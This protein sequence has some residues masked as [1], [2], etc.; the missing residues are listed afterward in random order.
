MNSLVVLFS[1]MAVA[2]AKPSHLV[3]FPGAPSAYTSESRVDVHS[4]PSI[5]TSAA[6]LQAKALAEGHFIHKRSAALVASVLGAVA[7]VAS[8]HQSRVDIK[9][10]PAVVSTY[11]SAPVLS[12][13]A[14]APFAYTAPL[15][16]VAAYS[17]PIATGVYG[18]HPW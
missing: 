5:V 11:A 2:T 16:R 9:S 14:A 13:Y 17:T 7:P 3:A 15:A 10:S 12:T 1:L 8:S 4:S 18:V 6:H